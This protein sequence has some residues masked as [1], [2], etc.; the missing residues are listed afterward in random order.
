MLD[1]SKDGKD[2]GALSALFV[3]GLSSNGMRRIWRCSQ[4]IAM[5][6][7]DFVGPN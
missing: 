1:L 2:Y 4:L 6:M 3:F 5:D 7:L